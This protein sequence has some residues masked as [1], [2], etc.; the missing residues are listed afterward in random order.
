MNSPSRSKSARP[1]R[2]QARRYTD[3]TTPGLVFRDF[4]RLLEQLAG[5]GQKK[6]RP[7]APASRRGR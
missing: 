5:E 4:V 2:A 1:P 6:S 3:S 7:R